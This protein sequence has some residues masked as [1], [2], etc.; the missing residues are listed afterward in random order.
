MSRI[1]CLIICSG[2]S[3]R[4]IASFRFARIKVPTR[5]KSPMIV[6]PSNQSS[7]PPAKQRQSYRQ[8]MFQRSREMRREVVHSKT[9]QHH[10]KDPQ[11]EKFFFSRHDRFPPNV[12]KAE[13]TSSRISRSSF[14][15]APAVSVTYSEAPA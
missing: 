2:S 8:E 4:S 6:L 3:A 12:H 13:V 11:D 7:I 10:R 15:A 1:T 14:V 5:S 9:N